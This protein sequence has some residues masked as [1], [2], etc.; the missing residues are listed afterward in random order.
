MRVALLQHWP[1]NGVRHSFGSYHLA[2]FQDAAKPA[3]EMGNSPAMIFKHYRE[4]V[5]PKD[6]EA[7]WNIRPAMA[8]NVVPMTA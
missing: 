6:A 2:H 1:Q 4:L 5:K 8:R 3:L 7:Y